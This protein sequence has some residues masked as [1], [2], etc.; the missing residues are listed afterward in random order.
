[1]P[2]TNAITSKAILLGD[3]HLM[4]HS[5]PCSSKPRA[6]AVLYH[7]FLAHGQYPTVRYAADCLAAAATSTTTTTT[8]AADFAVVSADLRGHGRSEGLIGFLSG[9]NQVIQDAVAIAE[10]AHMELFPQVEKVF[11]VGS[12]M[13]GTIALSVA[14]ELQQRKHGTMVVAGVV[15]LAPMLRLKVDSLSRTLLRGLAYAVPTW[16]IIPTST[17]EPQYRDPVKR[18][19]CADDEYAGHGS[20]IRVGSAST[21]VELAARMNEVFFS[22]FVSCP[23]L[24]LVADEDAVV[25]NQGALDLMEHAASSDKTIRHYPALHGLFCEPSPLVDEIGKDLVQW[26]QARC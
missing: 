8:A 2:E 21:C 13:G 1:M 18:Q 19:E 5:W 7:G 24:V 9:P 17:T 4:V 25:N 3:T 12:S 16:Q 26:M 6:L 23:L 11:L 10:Y 14:A 15:L 22:T 20:T